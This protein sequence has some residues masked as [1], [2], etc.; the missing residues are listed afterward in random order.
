M[1]TE[2]YVSF[3]VAK[4]LEDKGFD[5]YSRGSYD[6]LMKFH[7]RE[8]S[9]NLELPPNTE[10]IAPTLQMTMKWLREVHNIHIIAEPCFKEGIEAEL[11]FNRWFWTIFIESG[12]YKP[13]R[14]INEFPTYEKACEAAIKYCL[15]NLI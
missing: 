2:D 12:E 3:E 13:I 8:K 15:E 6:G 10:V 14:Q 1:I 7:E 4:L 5:E 11:D 9:H